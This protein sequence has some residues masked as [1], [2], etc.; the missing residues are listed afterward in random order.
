LLLAGLAVAA[1]AAPASAQAD[2]GIMRVSP[3]SAAPGQPVNVEIGCGWPK[4]CPDRIA[5]SVVLAHKVPKP[6]PC[7]DNALCSPTSSGPPRRAPYVFLGRATRTKRTDYLQR[8]ELSGR[9]PSL[10]PGGYAFV[11]YVPMGHQGT[12]ILI[13]SVPGKKPLQVAAKSAAVSAGQSSD[14]RST[15]LIVALAAVALLAATTVLQ[16]ARA[17]PSHHPA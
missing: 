9:L 14:S 10:R 15:W 1:L 6:H 8:Y 2:I 5:V 3:M 7:G 4:G 17:R 13:S 12:G 16:R 11:A